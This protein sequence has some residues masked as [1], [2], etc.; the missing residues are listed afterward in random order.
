MK[1]PKLVFT[2]VLRLLF[3][4]GLYERANAQQVIRLYEGKAPGSES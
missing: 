4:V 3:I 2:I 1:A